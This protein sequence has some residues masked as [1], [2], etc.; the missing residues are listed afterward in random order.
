MKFTFGIVTNIN[1]VDYIGN[2]SENVM[3]LLM[4]SNLKMRKK[5]ESNPLCRVG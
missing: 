5:R 3:I 2:N 4:S 1:V